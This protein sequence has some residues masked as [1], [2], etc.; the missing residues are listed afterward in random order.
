M[1]FLRDG[2]LRLHG[3]L[4]RKTV[5]ENLDDELRFLRGDIYRWPEAEPLMQRLSAADRFKAS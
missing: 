5:E 2:L 3:S 4:R 1:G